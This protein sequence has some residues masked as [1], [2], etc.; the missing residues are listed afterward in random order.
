MSGGRMGRKKVS[1]EDVTE[2]MLPRCL[3]NALNSL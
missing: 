3:W 2:E 1:D